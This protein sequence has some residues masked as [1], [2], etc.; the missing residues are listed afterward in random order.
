MGAPCEQMITADPDILQISLLP[1]DEFIILGCDGIWDCLTNQE[2]VD[3][4]RQRIET[5]PLADIGAEM[6]DRIVS[7]DPRVTQ[8][9][10]GDNMTCL[11]VDLKSTN[12][13]IYCYS[14]SN[15]TTLSSNGI[16][17]ATNEYDLI[18]PSSTTSTANIEIQSQHNRPDTCD[19]ESNSLQE[20]TGIQDSALP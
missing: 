1:D 16:D 9:I 11:I 3:F 10:G 4:V 17:C 19:F 5:T 2:C 7:K 13:Q 6:L 18:I 8:G 20:D 12:R 15:I 14:S